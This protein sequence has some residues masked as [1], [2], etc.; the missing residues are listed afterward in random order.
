[1]DEYEPF[2]LKI[3]KLTG[4]K[5]Q[6]ENAAAL[7]RQL[8]AEQGKPRYSIENRIIIAFDRSLN[9]SVEFFQTNRSILLEALLNIAYN[10]YVFTYLLREYHC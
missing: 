2:D 8:I 10:P 4:T 6:R 1:M 7:L 5:W 9:S 3:T